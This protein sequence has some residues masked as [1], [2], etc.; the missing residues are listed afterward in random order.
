[1]FGL[2]TTFDPVWASA[3]GEKR[4]RPNGASTAAA[5]N[6][7]S[8]FFMDRSPVLRNPIAHWMRA[9]PLHAG[10]PG[11]SADVSIR[12]VRSVSV[13]GSEPIDD[14]VRDRQLRLRWSVLTAAALAAG[15]CRRLIAV[16]RE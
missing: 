15:P 7:T 9:L 2:T 13:V 14:D 3:S 6:I 5:A 16:V 12:R 8:S 10:G 11:A 1:V 4:T